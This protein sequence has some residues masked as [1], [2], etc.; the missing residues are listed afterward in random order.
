MQE[1]FVINGCFETQPQIHIPRG[2]L[3]NWT[4]GGGGGGVA[5]RSES[6]TQ[7]YLSKHSNI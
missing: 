2:A 7:K 3:N 5:Q 4:Y 1:L 6:K